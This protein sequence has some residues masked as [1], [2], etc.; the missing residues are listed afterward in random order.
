MTRYVWPDAPDLLHSDDAVGRARHNALRRSLPGAVAGAAPAPVENAVP[1][2]AVPPDIGAGRS[3]VPVG[4]VTVL[5]GQAA[6]Q[7]RVAGRIREEDR[8]LYGKQFYWLARGWNLLGR[9]RLCPHRG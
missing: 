2:A 5:N 9:S 4:P 6:G 1:A 3:W 7:P 8:A